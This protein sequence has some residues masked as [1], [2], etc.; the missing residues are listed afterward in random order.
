MTQLIVGQATWWPLPQPK[1]QWAVSGA[2]V[3]VLAGA[4]PARGHG[5]AHAALPVAPPACPPGHDGGVL[6]VA[7]KRAISTSKHDYKKLKSG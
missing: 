3:A 4:G 7:W 2:G 5:G 6:S 1:Q